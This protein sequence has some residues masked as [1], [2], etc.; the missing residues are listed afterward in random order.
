MDTQMSAQ[1][2]PDDANGNDR[3]DL[4]SRYGLSAVASPHGKLHPLWI[5]MR[6][7]QEYG[8]DVLSDQCKNEITRP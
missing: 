3:D 4:Y 6:A 5:A 2:A 7:G 1:G 8:V